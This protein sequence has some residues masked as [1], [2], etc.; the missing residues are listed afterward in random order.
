MDDNKIKR[1]N[2]LYKKSKTVGLNEEE[3]EEQKVLRAEFIKGAKEQL[4]SQIHNIK[5]VD[6]NGNIVKDYS[7][8]K[9]CNCGEHGHHNH[10]CNCHEHSHNHEHGCSH[11]DKG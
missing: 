6:E 8:A 2:E 5:I 1:I 11:N 3:K 10:S 4:I 7:K 9:A